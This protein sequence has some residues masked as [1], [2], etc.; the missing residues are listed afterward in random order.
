MKYRRLTKEE[1]VE[2]EKEFIDYLASNTITGGDWEKMKKE[3]PEKAEKHIELFSDIVLNKVLSKVK[4]LE[5]KTPR[6]WKV[7]KC[8]PDKI[9]LLEF[10][11]PVE[12][13]FD[14][15]APEFMDNIN[16]TSIQLIKKQK[17]YSKERE[18]EIFEMLENGCFISEGEVFNV[19]THFEG[20]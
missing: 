9:Y 11:L 13:A 2:M 10:A 14:F 16:D 5:H 4:F 20:K 7:F 12:A 3:S 18:L 15:Y 17:A 19:M 8:M 1:L 6:N